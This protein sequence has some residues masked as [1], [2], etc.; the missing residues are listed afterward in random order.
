MVDALLLLQLLE[1]DDP[2]IRF[3]NKP[4]IVEKRRLH[5]LA[6]ESTTSKAFKIISLKVIIL[7]ELQSPQNFDIVCVDLLL[8]PFE[9]DGVLRRRTLPVLVQ[10]HEW[11]TLIAAL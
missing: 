11:R 5:L 8:G 10:S 1:V 3:E 7:L 6:S 4:F 2:S 9:A